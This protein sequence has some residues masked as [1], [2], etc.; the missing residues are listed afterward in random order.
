MQHVDWHKDIRMEN[1]IPHK[2]QRV[3][4]DMPDSLKKPIA[5]KRIDVFKGTPYEVEDSKKEKVMNSVIASVQ[6][7]EPYIITWEW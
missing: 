3:F 5:L 7:G 4:I 2:G 6:K 1:Y